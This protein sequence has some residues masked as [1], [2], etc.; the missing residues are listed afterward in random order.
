[1]TD[2]NY[3]IFPYI[4]IMSFICPNHHTYSQ[5]SYFLAIPLALISAEWEH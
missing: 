4:K 5:L 3:L 2:A 1:M